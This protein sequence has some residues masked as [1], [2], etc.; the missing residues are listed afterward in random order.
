M[1]RNVRRRFISAGLAV[2]LAMFGLA[3]PTPTHAAVVMNNKVPFLIA[4]FIPCVPEFALLNGNLHVLITSEVDSNGGTH[5]KSHFQPQGISGEGSVTGNKYQGTGVTQSHTN[6]HTS[7]ASETTFVNNFR[8]IG[9]G[10]GNNLLVHTTFHVT[11]NA[12]GEVTADVLNTSVEC[13]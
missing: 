11:V 4:P 12:N 1:K 9:P 8:I 13:K 7:L 5:F 2:A 10:P 6:T 3:L